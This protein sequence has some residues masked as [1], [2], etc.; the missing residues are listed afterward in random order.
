MATF[1]ILFF[2]LFYG[3]VNRWKSVKVVWKKVRELKKMIELN[4]AS[5]R[6]G[7]RPRCVFVYACACLVSV[8]MCMCGRFFTAARIGTVGSGCHQ[9]RACLCSFSLVL[10]PC[11]SRVPA[12]RMHRRHPYG[13]SRRFQRTAL[14]TAWPPVDGENFR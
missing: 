14:H 11:E 10:C 8:C 1:S 5:L 13:S 9:F 2:V 7:S 4:F 6:F 12:C 3:K